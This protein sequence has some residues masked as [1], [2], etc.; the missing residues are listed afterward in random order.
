V[1]FAEGKEFRLGEVTIQLAC[2]YA[3]LLLTA[4]DKNVTLAEAKSALLCAVARNSNSGFKY[5]AID[6]R[7][8]DNGRGPILLEPVRATVTFSKHSVATVNVLDHD[9]RRTGRSLP[10]TDGQ[11][12][13]DGARDK[14]L[15]YEVQF[16]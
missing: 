13:I 12:T 15:Y 6:S 9:G 8:L 10:V 16:R 7:T 4:L 1:G 14:T 5:F 3:S 11:F 2:P